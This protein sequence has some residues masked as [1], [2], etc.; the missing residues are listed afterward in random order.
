MSLGFF[1]LFLLYAILK[2]LV[3]HNKKQ[4]IINVVERINDFWKTNDDCEN[5]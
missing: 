5:K 3:A 2:F 1:I 4:F